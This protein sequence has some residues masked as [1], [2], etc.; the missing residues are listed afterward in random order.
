LFVALV[1]G[2]NLRNFGEPL[3]IIRNFGGPFPT[4]AIKYDRNLSLITS[5][6]IIQDKSLIRI[7]DISL[8][9]IQAKSLICKLIH[10]DLSNLNVVGTEPTFLR[11]W[12][13]LKRCLAQYLS[14]CS[15]LHLVDQRSL[16]DGYYVADVLTIPHHHE[17]VELDYE[18]WQ[19]L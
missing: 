11:R 10:D 8:F 12:H 17:V 14:H 3:A 7:H 18:R 5:L 19:Q 6:S 16:L 13:L 9:I 4:L 1:V 2:R 15:H